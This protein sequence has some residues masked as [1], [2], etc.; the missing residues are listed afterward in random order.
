MCT[1][2]L[3]PGVNPVAVNKYIISYI[4]N[5]ISIIISYH[6]EVFFL[7]FLYAC[8]PTCQKNE[9]KVFF[10]RYGSICAVEVYTHVFLTSALCCGEWGALRTGRFLLVPPPPPPPPPP[11]PPDGNY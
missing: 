11:N 1:V 8:R 7:L 6:N 5:H 9:A 4:S 10:A 3:P 2:L